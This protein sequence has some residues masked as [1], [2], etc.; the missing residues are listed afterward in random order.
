MFKLPSW[1][2][3]HFFAYSF[4]WGVDIKISFHFSF[5][6]G[7]KKKKVSISDLWL[8]SENKLH[9][10]MNGVAHSASEEVTGHHWRAPGGERV[11]F[12]TQQWRKKARVNGR[13]W[14]KTISAE[15]SP[16]IVYSSN[17]K[18]PWDYPVQPTHLG[19]EKTENQKPR[20]ICLLSAWARARI[21][22]SVPHFTP[23]PLHLETVV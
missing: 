20:K 1:W 4:S 17:L 15:T 7:S 12:L 14:R 22:A 11:H 6:P 19:D 16:E 2:H 21:W 10:E 13:K 18:G 5:Y 23:F 8:A 3:L 9:T